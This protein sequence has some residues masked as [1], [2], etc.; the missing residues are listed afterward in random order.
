MKEVDTQVQVV[1]SNIHPETAEV[2]DEFVCIHMR[3]QYTALNSYH[4]EQCRPFDLYVKSAFIKDS[5]R[6][7]KCIHK[8]VTK[9]LKIV[10][11]VV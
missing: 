2:K 7:A 1:L 10:L 4:A 3:A 11:S 5:Q 9:Y 8:N 6:L